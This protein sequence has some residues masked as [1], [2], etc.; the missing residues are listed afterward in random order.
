MNKRKCINCG[1][2]Y[3]TGKEYGYW[4]QESDLF[5]QYKNIELKGLC[6]FCNPNN[7]MWFLKDRAKKYEIQQRNIC[8]D[9]K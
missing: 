5:S 7:L 3:A 6:E 8:S 1:A 4:W 2:I 9:T